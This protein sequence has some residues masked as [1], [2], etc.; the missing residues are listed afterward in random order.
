MMS[1]PV[2]LV[3]LLGP[4][5]AVVLVVFLFIKYLRTTRESQ[6]VLESERLSAMQAIH[7]S[8]HAQGQKREEQLESVLDRTTQAL[9]KH[10][11]ISGSVLEALRR[12]NGHH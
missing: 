10:A 4:S 12:L 5:A 3:E 11:E 9:E 2:T 7:D 1:D 8:C 6:D